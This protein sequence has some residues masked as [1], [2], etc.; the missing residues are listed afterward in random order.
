MVYEC[1]M[2]ALHLDGQKQITRVLAPATQVKLPK[3]TSTSTRFLKPETLKRV[4]MAVSPRS[5]SVPEVYLA[6]GLNEK[7]QVTRSQSHVGLGAVA[8]GLTRSS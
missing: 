5:A 4:N 2:P 1:E 8:D 3:R 6:Q 7:L